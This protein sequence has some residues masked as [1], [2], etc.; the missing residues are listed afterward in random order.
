MPGAPDSIVVAALGELLCTC[1]VEHP[2]VAET[3]LRVLDDCVRESGERQACELAAIFC[4]CVS[5][6]CEVSVLNAASPLILTQHS[7]ELR[8][9]LRQNPDL[10]ALI[11]RALVDG[12]HEHRTS[13]STAHIYVYITAFSCGQWGLDRRPSAK[14]LIVGHICFTHVLRRSGLWGA[15]CYSSHEVENTLWNEE[16]W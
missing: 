13:H 8:L 16:A 10:Y 1:L 14:L 4:V 6:V 5:H 7:V 11:Q 3:A 12:W 15:G 2:A 9:P